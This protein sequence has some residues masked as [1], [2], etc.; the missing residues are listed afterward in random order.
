[1]G[2]GVEY[3]APVFYPDLSLGPIAYI[4]RIRLMGFINAGK[5]KSV[6]ENNYFESPTTLG[7]EI[8]FDLNLFR[9]NFLFDLGF[10]FSYLLNDSY[11]QNQTSFELTLGSI[12][13]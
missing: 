12:T 8:K 3:E 9:Q 10:R 1:M 6:G 2:G 13:F 4:Q 7:G 5:V 11:N